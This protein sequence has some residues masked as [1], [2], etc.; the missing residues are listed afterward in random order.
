MLKVIGGVLIVLSCTAGG[1]FFA[2]A[3]R[4]RQEFLKDFLSFLH[5]LKIRLRYSSS[6]IRT[7]IPQCSE[8]KL[9]QPMVSKIQK[10]SENKAFYTLWKEWISSIPKSMGLLSADKKAL[11]EFGS[12]LGMTDVQGQLSHID[13]Y[14]SVFEKHLANARE[15][16][17]QKSKLYKS[18]GFFLGTS[19]ALMIV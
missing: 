16:L 19:I 15:N 13:L 3:L 10:V 14:V 5:A 11:A 7:L 6:D 17:N 1:F 18:L 2:S 8:S 12:E 9:L 4:L